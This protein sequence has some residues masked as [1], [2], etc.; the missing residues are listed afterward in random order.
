[1]KTVIIIFLLVTIAVLS[2]I[3][4][5]VDKKESYCADI[6]GGFKSPCD[7]TGYCSIN[8]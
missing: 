3:L 4:D 8:S 1:M 7:C 6:T 5:K 2:I